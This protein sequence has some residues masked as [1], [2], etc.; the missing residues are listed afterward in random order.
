MG[1]VTLGF[2]TIAD[3]K[4][5]EML[6]QMIA[7]WKLNDIWIHTSE[8]EA[9]AETGGDVVLLETG[10]NN[11]REMNRHDWDLQYTEIAK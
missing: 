11:R 9:R 6:R 7:E 4:R 3:V 10:K 1:I 5:K 8:Q 2:N